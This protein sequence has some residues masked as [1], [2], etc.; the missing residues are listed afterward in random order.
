MKNLTIEEIKLILNDQEKEIL[1]HYLNRKKQKE[2]C[3]LVGCTRSK[4]DALVSKF[5]L[6]RFRDRKSY[7][8]NDQ[9]LT[10]DNP[11]FWYF[12]GLF[13]SDGNMYI[14][15]K[16]ERVQFT[17]KDKD[18]IESIVSILGYTGPINYY[19]KGGKNYYQVTISY[20]PLNV[21]IKSVF[22]NVY[23]KTDNIRFL[24]IYKKIHLQLFLRGFIDG[25]GCF[26]KTKV[27]DKYLFSIYCKS[28]SFVKSLYKV[29]KF[30]TKGHVCL[31]DINH[32]E[33][34][35]ITT[36][37]LLYKFLYQDYLEI[38]IKRKQNRAAQHIK[39]YTN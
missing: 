5:K 8:C 28:V 11:K 15:D 16:V 1:K 39:K 36:N 37:T 33:L 14:T 21:L 24:S 9:Y 35:S 6:T 30:I 2:I 29:L 27:P 32:I 4:I 10:I 19:N 38:G 12:L 17:M 7:I 13:A 20:P 3:T 31:Y 34:S 23:R 18:A 22:G 26:R 25:D